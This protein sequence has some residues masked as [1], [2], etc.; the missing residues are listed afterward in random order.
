MVDVADLVRAIL[1]EADANDRGVAF[2]G[3]I[4]GVGIVPVDEHHS[5]G[6]HDVY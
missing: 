3:D 2:C 1:R 6:G 5:L 4:D